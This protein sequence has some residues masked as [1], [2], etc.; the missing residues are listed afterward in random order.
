MS[1]VPVKLLLH[2]LIVFFM[3][4]LF[5][6]FEQTWI[7]TAVLMAALPPALNV[8]VFGAAIRHLGRAGSGVVLIGTLVSVFTLTSVM[9]LV[10]TGVLPVPPF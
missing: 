4:S 9:W 3:L 1:I 6:P 8:F 10:K 2:P 5:G 7:Y